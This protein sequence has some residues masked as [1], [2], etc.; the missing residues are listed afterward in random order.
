MWNN[1]ISTKLKNIYIGFGVTFLSLLAL[2][3]GSLKL[4][5]YLISIKGG[6]SLFEVPFLAFTYLVAALVGLVIV[7]RYFN[8]QKKTK[9]NNWFDELNC[10]LLICFLVLLHIDTL[11][12]MFFYKTTIELS[13]ID[14]TALVFYC[15]VLYQFFIAPKPNNK[16]KN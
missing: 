1:V 14:I 2:I 13:F 3:A 10:K 6:N 7:Y 16:V 9:N 15:Y 8:T 5:G 11:S 12:K 4:T